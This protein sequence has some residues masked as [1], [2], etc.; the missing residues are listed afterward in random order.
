MARTTPPRPVDVAALFPELVSFRREATRLHP[1][2]GDP[3][4]RE[5]SVGG[6]LLWPADEPWPQCRHTHP[7]PDSAGPHPLVP[8]LQLFAADIPDLPFPP[9]TDLMQLLWCP[10]DH[11]PYYSPRPELFWRTAAIDTPLLS[12][13]P[14]PANAPKNYLPD[15]CVLDPERIVEYPQWDLAE[16]L[17]EALSARFDKLEEATG[18]SYWYELSVA[19]G[20]KVGGYPN[21]TQEPDWPNCN[22]CGK[23]MNHLLSVDSSEFDGGSARTWLP[24]E[25]RPATGKIFDLPF[26]DRKAIQSAPGLMIGDMGGVYVFICPNCSDRP[27]AYRSDCS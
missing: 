14:R 19:P 8:V 15:P 21:W 25:D 12:L 6:P 26:E 1:R 3:G 7:E 9:G 24:I 11:E 27:C 23:R 4:M 5:S 17:A 22:G 18:W 10:F 16:N 20:V 13:P 2:R